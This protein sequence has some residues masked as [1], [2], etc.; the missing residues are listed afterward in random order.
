MLL[1][2]LSL[3]V[4]VCKCNYGA[5]KEKIHINLA[6]FGCKVFLYLLGTFS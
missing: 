4:A 6:V 5:L 3:F 1:D 2:R